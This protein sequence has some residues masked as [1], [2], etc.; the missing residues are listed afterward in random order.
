MPQGEQKLA[1]AATLTSTICYNRSAKVTS[2]SSLTPHCCG[3]TY[4]PE[5]GFHSEIIRN[6]CLG[7][8]GACGSLK[9]VMIWELPKTGGTLLWGPYNKDPTISGTILGSPIFGNRHIAIAAT[10]TTATART[11]D[12]WDLNGSWPN[13]IFQ[14]IS[15]PKIRTSRKDLGL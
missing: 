10:T 2:P 15:R 1:T 13:N 9:F 12:S 7:S 8:S 14:D 11:H 3:S 6:P 4:L 5:H